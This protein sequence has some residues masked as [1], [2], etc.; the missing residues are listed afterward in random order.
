MA[1]SVPRKF[2]CNICYDTKRIS[3]IVICNVCD[4]GVCRDCAI[5]IKCCPYC[6][7]GYKHLDCRR[8]VINMPNMGDR[9][10]MAVL[11]MVLLF[12][13]VLDLIWTIRMWL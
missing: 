4:N 12:K 11:N 7:I 6:K 10:I 13:V 3:N 8:F 9:R 2:E 1:E 5:G